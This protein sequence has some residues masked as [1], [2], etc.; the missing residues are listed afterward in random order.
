MLL[1]MVGL[2]YCA[3]LTIFYG[4]SVLMWKLELR[5]SFEH[6]FFLLLNLFI[7]IFLYITFTALDVGE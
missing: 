5:I 7:Y 2:G 4:S 6:F 1:S 3:A